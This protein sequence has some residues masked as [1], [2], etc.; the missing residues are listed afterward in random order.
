[1]QKSTYALCGKSEEDVKAEP[2]SIVAVMFATASVV[3]GIIF[4]TL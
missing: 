3:V 2:E 1:M 4:I